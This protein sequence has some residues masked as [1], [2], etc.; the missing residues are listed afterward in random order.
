MSRYEHWQKLHEKAI[1]N[2]PGGK[3]PEGYIE[4]E[5]A[6]PPPISSVDDSDILDLSMELNAVSIDVQE[7]L[8]DSGL[9]K[10]PMADP[11]ME[12]SA[13]KSSIRDGKFGTDYSFVA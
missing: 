9:E 11:V 5:H 3:L 6:P 2:A 4:I 8:D 12:V 10:V 13:R 7:Q 1:R